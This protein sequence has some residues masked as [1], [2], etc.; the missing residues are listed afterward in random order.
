MKEMKVSLQIV[1]AFSIL[2]NLV[3][4]SSPNPLKAGGTW[5]ITTHRKRPSP[6]QG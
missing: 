4:N 2:I 1:N 3:F 6:D 5:G